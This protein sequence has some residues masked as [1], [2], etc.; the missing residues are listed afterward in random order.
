[1]IQKILKLILP[2]GLFQ[3]IEE[4]SKKWTMEC[5]KC[6]YTISYWEAGGVRAG[7]ANNN[8]K[9]LGRCPTCQKYKFLN[10]VK[11]G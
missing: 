10:V 6:G 9:V 8:K 5:P 4:E 7:A 2:Q 3:K 1:M 11:R